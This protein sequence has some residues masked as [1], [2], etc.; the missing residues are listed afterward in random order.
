MVKNPPSNAGD[1]G[2]VFGWGTKIPLAVGK[3]SLR[4]ATTEPTRS[5]AH[6]ATREKPAHRNRGSCMPQQ[7]IPHAA[8]KILCAATKT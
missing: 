2:S 5:R 8:T 6:A 3:Q 7:R 1:A 4:A